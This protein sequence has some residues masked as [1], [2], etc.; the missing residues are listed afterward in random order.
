L[1]GL[2][3]SWVLSARATCCWTPATKIFNT[4][5][6]IFASV[7][8]KGYGLVINHFARLGFLNMDI[9]IYSDADVNIGM[10][11]GLKKAY[12]II[13]SNSTRVFYN[14]IEKDYG[15]KFEKIKLKSNFIR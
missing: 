13:A 15:T 1:R 4:E 8:G 12:P 14:T 10:Y 3:A 7:N 11:H 5:N 2:C 6:K 9:S